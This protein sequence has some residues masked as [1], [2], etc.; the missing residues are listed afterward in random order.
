MDVSNEQEQDQYNQPSESEETPQTDFRQDFMQT[1]GQNNQLKMNQ[2]R[3]DDMHVPSYG[4]EF[5]NDVYE[6]YGQI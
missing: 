4:D 6:G 2:Q 5:D 3:N 1:F